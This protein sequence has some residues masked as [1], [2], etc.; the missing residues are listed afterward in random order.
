MQESD[1][2]LIVHVDGKK[3]ELVLSIP[4]KLDLI[5]PNRPAIHLSMSKEKALLLG[6]HITE[7]AGLMIERCENELV[8]DDGDGHSK[9]ESGVRK[10]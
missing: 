10:E 6:R 5:D 4:L 2:K 8:I 3:N 7:Q 1:T 9:P